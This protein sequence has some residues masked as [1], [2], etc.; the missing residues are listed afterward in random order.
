MKS[1]NGHLGLLIGGFVALMALLF[2]F[3]GGSLGGKTT[4]DSDR[5][6][7]PIADTGD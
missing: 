2:I 1:E 7:P 4:V 5:D 3:S 6:L